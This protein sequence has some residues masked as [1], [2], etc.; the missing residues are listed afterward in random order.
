MSMSLSK[1]QALLVALGLVMMVSS[2]GAV[3]PETSR[4]DREFQRIGL[5]YSVPSI[6][7]SLGEDGVPVRTT[8]D[9]RT[10]EWKHKSPTKAFALSFVVPGLGQYYYGSKTKPLLFAGIEIT[11]WVLYANWRS[12]GNRRTDEFEAFADQHW[13]ETKYV[14]YLQTV[15][16]IS[17]DE[18][19]VATELSH[20]LPDTRTQQYYEMIGKYDQFAWGWDDA[21]MDSAGQRVYEPWVAI[22]HPSLAP[23][24][25]RRD[26]YEKMRYDANSKLRNADK[27][28]MVSLANHLISALEAYFV[29]KANNRKHSRQQDE[30]AR[31]KLRAEIRSY[32]ALHDTPYFKVSYKF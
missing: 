3:N 27:M 17:D 23:Q 15:Y 22:T 19:T 12:D 9:D 6:T 13:L 26:L 10:E 31:L 30:F 20:H 24:S 11:S 28:I 2:A 21:Y 1:G 29:T 7:A 14:D 4:I 5:E 32:S 16:G 25:D 18:D 8:A